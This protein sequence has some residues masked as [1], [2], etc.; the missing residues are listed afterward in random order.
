[1]SRHIG[2]FVAV[3]PSSWNHPVNG[4]GRVG[5]IREADALG[6]AQVWYRTRQTEQQI[7]AKTDTKQVV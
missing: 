5:N 2:H 1:M 4:G 7:G 3:N 6:R